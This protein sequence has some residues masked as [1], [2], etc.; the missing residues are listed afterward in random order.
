M[1]FIKSLVKKAQWFLF[2]ISTNYCMNNAYQ[3]HA[4]W[5]IAVVVSWFMVLLRWLLRLLVSGQLIGP[6]ACSWRASL[7]I[8]CTYRSTL[9]VA[10][11]KNITLA[12]LSSNMNINTALPACNSNFVTQTSTYCARSIRTK[13]LQ[14]PGFLL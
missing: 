4:L 6:A 10:H 14:N 7:F 1:S 12:V 3:N 13:N 2:P 9:L 8:T 5:R 11:Y